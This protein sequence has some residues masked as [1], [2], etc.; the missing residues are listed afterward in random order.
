[1]SKALSQ[2]LREN[3]RYLKEGGWKNC[4]AL[5]VAAANEIDRL[6]A[7]VKQL[8]ERAGHPGTVQDL[9]RRLIARRSGGLPGER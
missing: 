1:V 5:M 4:A 7:H 2:E 6:D 3:C 9:V 8:E